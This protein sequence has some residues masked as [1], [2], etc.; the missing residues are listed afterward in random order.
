MEV[1]FLQYRSFLCLSDICSCLIGTGG[2]TGCADLSS[3]SLTFALVCYSVILVIPL[4]HTMTHLCFIIVILLLLLGHIRV[5]R[6]RPRARVGTSTSAS[7]SATPTLRPISNMGDEGDEGSDTDVFC[8][9]GNL[10]TILGQS[11]LPLVV[12]HTKGGSSPSPFGG[13]GGPSPNKSS[14]SSSLDHPSTLVLPERVRAY[15]LIAQRGLGRC[16]QELH[17]TTSNQGLG[18]KSQLETTS[19]SWQPIVLVEA[20]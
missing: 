9:E 7:S 15:L 13:L 12:E 19:K 6:L 16:L 17:T 1:L 2:S 10:N 20:L 18:F 5:E 14:S 8:W 11:S 4:H 3:A